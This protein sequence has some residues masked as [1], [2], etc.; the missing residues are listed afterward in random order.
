MPA[1]HEQVVQLGNNPSSHASQMN[2]RASLAGQAALRNS[3]VRN[4]HIGEAV[5][6]AA[7]LHPIAN[8]SCHSRSRID[9]YS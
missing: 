9:D 3:Q 6:L 8:L 5:L 1:R 4:R 2:F 7:I